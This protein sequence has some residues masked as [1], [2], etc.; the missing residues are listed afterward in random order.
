MAAEHSTENENEF[1]P[2]RSDDLIQNKQI[3]TKMLYN[4]NLYYPYVICIQRRLDGRGHRVIS[5][6]LCGP[7]QQF[8]N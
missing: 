5:R 6:R 3:P 1:S 2:V 4:T 7:P 8:L